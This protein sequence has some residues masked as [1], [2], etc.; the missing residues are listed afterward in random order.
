[1]TAIQ[2][3]AVLLAVL[4]PSQ[5]FAAE[6]HVVT[7]GQ[8]RSALGAAALQRERNLA[9]VHRFFSDT[10]VREVLSKAKMDPDGLQSA[11][12]VLDDAELAQ[13]AAKARE[14]QTQI[15]GAGLELSNQQVTLIILIGGLIVFTAIFVIAFK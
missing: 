12:A 10:R 7:Q 9:D 3:L 5:M 15:T 6:Q 2:I 8:L 1:M 11:A 4:I 14:A 13:L